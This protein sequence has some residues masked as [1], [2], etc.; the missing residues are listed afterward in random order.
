[1]KDFPIFFVSG[2]PRAGSTLLMNLLGQNP[3]HHVTP[4]S[5]LIG[6]L[7]KIKS[8]WKDFIEFK[9]EGLEKVKP[10]IMGSL[11]GLMYGHFEKEFDAGKVV[12]DKSRGWLNYIEDVEQMLGRPI[13]L[14][15]P[16][17]DVRDICASFE[18]IYQNRSIEYNY[19]LGDAFFKCQTIVG[20]S[21]YLLSPGGVV[22]IAINR[23]RD[24]LQRQIKNRLI[25]LPATALTTKPLMVLDQIHEM[26]G[27][28]KFTYNPQAVE[29]I[30]QENDLW[31][32]MDLHKVKP[33][34]KPIPTGTWKGILPD[35][36]AIDLAKRYKDI[37]ELAAK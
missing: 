23:V 32:G 11:K 12:F 19:P 9:A 18:K 4:T 28:P 20:R 14:L 30:T 21:E 2:L 6:I 31:H 29:Q 36:Y 16:I 27:L 34:V 7:M 13:K 1:M 15:V 10:R 22:G 33:E 5:G 25:I 37:N 24:A 26:L 3:N 35:K 8:S 17:R